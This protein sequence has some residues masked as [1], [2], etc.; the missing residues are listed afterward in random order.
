MK[1][2]SRARP[3]RPDSHPISVEHLN[4]VLEISQP[5]AARLQ[6]GGRVRDDSLYIARK[7]DNILLS[8]ITNNAEYC[9][10]LAPRQIGKSSL[11]SHV[12]AT[13]RRSGIRVIYLDL[14]EIGSTHGCDLGIRPDPGTGSSEGNSAPVFVWFDTLIRRLITYL[15]YDKEWESAFFSEHYGS[16]P[17]AKLQSLFHKTAL[18]TTNPL[19]FIFDE[20]DITLSS[21]F[22]VDDFFTVLR[23][24]YNARA[25][26]PQYRN[27]IVC[28]VG[29]ASVAQLVRTP[30]L[31]PFSVGIDVRIEDFT[32]TEAAQF[33]PVL[34]HAFANASAAERLF[35]RVW[36]WTH[37]HP[38]MTQRLCAALVT[39]GVGA[40][41]DALVEALF[42]SDGLVNDSSLSESLRRL[43]N[44]P[45]YKDLLS[46][47]YK[48]LYRKAI[49]IDSNSDLQNEMRLT[50]LCRYERGRLVVRN[51]IY[52]EVFDRAWL[53][54]KRAGAYLVGRV[55][56]WEEGGRKA[57][58]L[59]KAEELSE[60]AHLVK[61][62]RHLSAIE[63][64]MV[65]ESQLREREE[66]ARAREE[67]EL[68]LQRE[69]QLR[70]A[71]Q[72]RRQRTEQDLQ[73]T[74]LAEE[75]AK[76]AKS[77][78]A[79]R[80]E[81]AEQDAARAMLDKKQADQQRIQTRQRA[82]R[83][84][85]VGSLVAAVAIA[86]V[87]YLRGQSEKG[88]LTERLRRER[89]QK[90]SAILVA[91][92]ARLREDEERQKKEAQ[93]REIA[94]LAKA[95]QALQKQL[96]AERSV[97][98][99]E[100][101]RLKEWNT[102]L[103]EETVNQIEL[104]VKNPE[105][106]PVALING[107]RVLGSYRAL[108]G[109]IEGK[110][111]AKLMAALPSLTVMHELVHLHDV[112]AVASS[113]DQQR[114]ATGDSMGVVRI[115]QADNLGQERVRIDSGG[116][117][118]EGHRAFRPIRALA[119]SPDGRVLASAAED[120]SVRLWDTGNGA[121]QRILRMQSE[122]V[123]GI[124]F[125]PDG[126][127]LVASGRGGEVRIWDLLTGQ[128][129][130]VASSHGE[131]NDVRFLPVFG[132]EPEVVSAHGNGIA[133]RWQRDPKHKIWREH[134]RYVGNKLAVLSLAIGRDGKDVLTA[135]E[136]RVV[137][138]FD[139]ST[140]ELVHALAEHTQP[141][142]SVDVSA[143]GDQIL[144]G[145]IDHTVRLW[146][147]ESAT[148]LQK[149]ADI[150]HK[151]IRMVRYVPGSTLVLTAAAEKVARLSDA[152]SS[153]SLKPFAWAAHQKQVLFASFA[154]SNDTLVTLGRDG[155]VVAWD[156]A[157]K[158]P[159][160]RRPAN[161][162]V[163]EAVAVDPHGS[164][165]G[166]GHEDGGIEVFHIRTGARERV[167]AQ[168]H[169]GRIRRLRIAPDRRT[170]M[171]SGDDQVL[172]FWDL[173]TGKR[174]AQA[175]P[176]LPVRDAQ[177]TPDGR[178][179]VVLKQ[180]GQL[181][182]ISVATGRSASAF[183]P[184]AT[185]FAS[186]KVAAFQ[187]TQ[188]RG[189]GGALKTMLL[190][191]LQDNPAVPG[192][193]LRELSMQGLN[194]PLAKQYMG[195]PLATD[196]RVERIELSPSGDTFL[197]TTERG[198]VQVRDVRHNSSR[199]VL[200]VPQALTDQMHVHYSSDGAQVAMAGN[201]EVGRIFSM[202]DALF[203]QVACG[204]MSADPTQRTAFQSVQHYCKDALA[205]VQPK[206]QPR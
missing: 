160:W 181:D 28:L 177:F 173:S 51:R 10:I 63:Q 44:S 5:G 55:T 8:E 38:F 17:A 32:E 136:D 15:G 39:E 14:S 12:G 155:L 171:A 180:N 74:K 198:V 50:G 114:Y 140:G 104:W 113:K 52:S 97:R 152:S 151:G 195:E 145:S 163:P 106:R 37:G 53:S 179:A 126:Q 47:Y 62:E 139:A 56:Q 169:I 58:G 59:L 190:A 27:I 86:V 158:T 128:S 93:K 200:H 107:I 134:G 61:K 33:L 193:E 141:V 21:S 154:G 79:L 13:L 96:R 202:S 197:L 73:A 166:I 1:K 108:Y 11:V 201:D 46:L 150:H 41:V 71:E 168:A 174:R 42:L 4:P 182:F 120:G 70:E 54:T 127:W 199:L 103:L 83:I 203:M 77:R 116:E 29:V 146:D 75:E 89:D 189:A 147:R 196:D 119:F 138:V 133:Y 22:A 48:L 153:I 165:V 105:T 35:R 125:S 65:F 30:H 137:R 76:Q 164:R 187:V 94:S 186:R 183:V 205:S 18:A 34:A 26:V 206:T 69:E 95:K 91:K 170:I 191:A 6:V 159:L 176:Q 49:P 118:Q 31:S 123:T 175:I 24:I 82:V 184:L 115:W 87:L 101:E 111:V 68:K 9:H 64:A 188:I 23:S 19:V 129:E 2:K 149:L 192:I 131:S 124:D 144:S 81:Q 99:K 204:M 143:K 16:T 84:G 130:Q 161:K 45:N 132:S 7:A 72:L 121:N 110:L 36:D 80:R 66:A 88:W 3:S 109:R 135:G 112:S 167:I 100:S 122:V 156:I 57:E 60:V 178:T 90:E 162:V 20:I 98:D 67:A 172:T 102:R 142:L 148:Q 157:R 78:E 43:E 194:L 92:E 40:D 185:Q 85:L 117:S 25:D